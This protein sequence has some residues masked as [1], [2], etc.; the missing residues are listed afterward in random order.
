MVFQNYRNFIEMT[1]TMIYIDAFGGGSKRPPKIYLNKQC[2]YILALSGSFFPWKGLQFI[3]APLPTSNFH[4]FHRLCIYSGHFFFI[5][6]YSFF[7]K[8]K[9]REGSLSRYYPLSV[10]CKVMCPPET[11]MLQNLKSVFTFLHDHSALEFDTGEEI[12]IKPT[13]SVGWF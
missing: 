6:S 8:T 13:T 7:S 9:K 3:Y 10:F 5:F 2:P 11:N 4:I 12:W 1:S